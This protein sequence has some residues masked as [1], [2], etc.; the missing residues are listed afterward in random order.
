[1][2]YRGLDLNLLT[3]LDALLSERNVS[4]AARRLFVSQSGMST[5]LTKLRAHFDD[6]LLVQSGRKMVLTELGARLLPSVHE[7]MQS[8]DLTLDLGLKFDPASSKRHFYI[9][10]SDYISEIMSARIAAISARCAP[11]VII[12]LVR[13]VLGENQSVDRGDIDILIA[14]SP[15]ILGD[16][17][18][19]ELYNEDHVILGW[20]G[21]EKF[22]APIT[23]QIFFEMGHVGVRLG[24]AAAGPNTESDR[25]ISQMP[26]KR[27]VEMIC[28]SLN[29][30]PRLL[31]GT[32]RIA[33]MQRRYAEF[34]AQTLPLEIRPVPFQLP[35]LRMMMQVHRSKEGDAGVQWLKSV[36]RESISARA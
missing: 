4:A 16:H 17:P 13:M 11:Q 6:E 2:R 33:I 7:L 14:V 19:E 26:E 3:A 27:R 35:K 25:Y 24:R 12:E 18:A 28:S 9:S 1:V 22:Q 5:I 23:R 31:I 8:V 10:A 29:L 34:A 21:N 15:Y 36:I 20:Q 32:Q 30:V